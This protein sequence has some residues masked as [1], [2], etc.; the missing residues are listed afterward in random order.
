MKFEP[1]Y[2]SSSITVPCWKVYMKCFP[3][4]DVIK[5]VNCFLLCLMKV[6]MQQVLLRAKVI[7]MM[8]SSCC[9][10][11]T[12]ANYMRY[13]SI[14][15]CPVFVSK[16]KPTFTSFNYFHIWI[17]LWPALV[18]FITMYIWTVVLLRWLIKWC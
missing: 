3:V 2:L 17:S 9:R 13:V 16:Q 12:L 1:L 15:F 8:Q 5:N 6:W 4:C 10:S 18:H 11:I 7:L 14:L